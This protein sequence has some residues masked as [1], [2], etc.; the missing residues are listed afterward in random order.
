VGCEARCA[1][2]HH[3]RRK[4]CRV[5]DPSG[6]KVGM[7]G[8]E[9]PACG[10]GICGWRK[11]AQARGGILP[12]RCNAPGQRRLISD[13]G[14]FFVSSSPRQKDAGVRMASLSSVVQASTPQPQPQL[15]TTWRRVRQG[16]A[17]T[18]VSS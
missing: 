13:G 1:A 14:A 4:I 16:A 3:V 10:A 6:L 18:A 2:K 9:L 12:L 17:G 15:M 5:L 11:F 7:H 8:L